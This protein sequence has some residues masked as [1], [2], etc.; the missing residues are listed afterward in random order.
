MTNED[1]I[2][3]IKEQCYVFDPL[4]LDLTIMV[5]TALDKA[6][7]AL[8]RDAEAKRPKKEVQS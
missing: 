8:M 4:N 1:A 3:I 2:E 7:I 6:I 5:N